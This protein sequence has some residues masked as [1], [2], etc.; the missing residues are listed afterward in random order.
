MVAVAITGVTAGAG[1]GDKAGGQA[2][3]QAGGQAGGKAGGKAVGQAAARGLAGATVLVVG[4]GL[5]GTSIGL[6]LHGLSRVL[7]ADREVSHVDVAASRGAGQPWDGR[8]R[9]DLAVL[10]VPPAAVPMVAARLFEQGIA[11]TL[12]HVSSVQSHLAAHIETA[13]GSARA[14]ICGGH[15]LAGR[16]VRGPEAATARLFVDRPWAVCP[17]EST[18]QDVV[19]VVEALVA[20]CG[21]VP[22]RVSPAEHDLAVAL[23]SHLPQL[24]ASGL[25]AQLLGPAASSLATTLAGPGLQDSTR[26]A[27]SDPQLWVEILRGNARHVAPLVRRLAEDL[28]A[29]ANALDGLAGATGDGGSTASERCEW[30]LT[31]LLQRGNRGRALVP[32]KAASELTR[33][34]VET[35]DRPGQLAALFNAAAAAGINV[36]DVRVEHLRGRARGL[37]ELLVAGHSADAARTALSVAG[38]QVLDG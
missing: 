16:E 6:A 2:V 25:A 36:E 18:A 37:V 38:W 3:G 15:P 4:T 1:A 33:V 5:I 34:V 30:V 26:I 13:M 24:V 14:R 12:S 7:L 8:E 20:A 11:S 28:S 17:S 29:A 22:V 21:A 10:A 32:L 31:D 9:V 23:V 27:A 35:D 19:L